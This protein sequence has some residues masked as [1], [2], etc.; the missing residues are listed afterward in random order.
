MP[1]EHELV[2]IILV[3]QFLVQPLQKGDAGQIN[4]VRAEQR[5]QAK[6]EIEQKSK[7]RPHRANIP[8]AGGQNIKAAVRDHELSH[9]IA[10]RLLGQFRVSTLLWSRGRRSPTVWGET[11]GLRGER[12]LKRG[13]ASVF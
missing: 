5:H 12:Q 6:D 9:S 1:Q 3:S 2:E 13:G 7:T 11:R 8:G 4:R 10:N